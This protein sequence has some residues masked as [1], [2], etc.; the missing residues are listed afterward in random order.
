MNL[1]ETLNKAKT[2]FA[3]KVSG[4]G[5]IHVYTYGP[6]KVSSRDPKVKVEKRGD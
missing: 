5:Q 6:S 2:D 1:T 4:S 3:N